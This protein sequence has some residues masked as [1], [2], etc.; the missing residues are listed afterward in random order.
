[1]S[2]GSS[3]RVPG[4]SPIRPQM[5]TKTPQK[6]SRIAPDDDFQELL[7]L[8]RSM[9]CTKRLKHSD[10]PRKGP[11]RAPSGPQKLHVSGSGP[12]RTPNSSSCRQKER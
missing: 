2:H 11:K 5:L 6:R 9:V 7:G 1:M 3:E 12:K 8:D 4:V 10:T